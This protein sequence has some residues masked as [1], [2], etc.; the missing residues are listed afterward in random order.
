MQGSADEELKAP[1]VTDSGGYQ[2]ARPVEQNGSGGAG[3]WN[4]GINQGRRPQPKVLVSQKGTGK[5]DAGDSKLT[6]GE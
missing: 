3:Q 4:E 6:E 5:Q 1:E 2:S